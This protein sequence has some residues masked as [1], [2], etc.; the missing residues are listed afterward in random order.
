MFGKLKGKPAL[1]ELERD[2]NIQTMR[3]GDLEIQIYRL[4]KAKD[5][6]IQL[7]ENL[8]KQGASLKEKLQQEAVQAAAQGK[9]NE[10][11]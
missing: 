4:K 11:N 6:C 3:L 5:R 10:A 2:F 1:E 7:L 9:P 8:N